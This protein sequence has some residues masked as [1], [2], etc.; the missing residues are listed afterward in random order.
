MSN[1]S[2]LA[3]T[4][5]AFSGPYLRWLEKDVLPIISGTL[6][7]CIFM[8]GVVLNGLTIHAVRKKRVTAL[9]THLFLQLVVLDFVA[10]VF[11]IF[12]AII[13]SF[14]KDWVLSEALCQISGAIGT[15]C[16][17]CLFIFLTFLCAE[18]M[19]KLNNPSVHD[20]FFGNKCICIIT[21]IVT[22]VVTFI[23]SILPVAGWGKLE[24][25]SSQ[26]RC[27][28]NHDKNKINMNLIFIFGMFLPAFM[29]FLFSIG[30][31]LQ[32]KELLTSLKSLTSYVNNVNVKVR[33]QTRAGGVTEKI[34]LGEI[35]GDQTQCLPEVENVNRVLTSTEIEVRNATSPVVPQTSRE[36]PTDNSLYPERPNSKNSIIVVNEETERP[37]SR[38][39]VSP[40]TEVSGSRTTRSE[41]EMK[42]KL[43]KDGVTGDETTFE[44][45]RVAV[46]VYK[47]SQEQVDF[48]LAATYMLIWVIV[49]MLWLPYVI[50]WYL[51]VYDVVS[52][53]GGVY[54]V[55]VIVC[56]VSY[57]IKPIVFM[58]HNHLFR[59]ATS[60]GV[61]ESLKTRVARAKRVLSKTARRVDGLIFLK[62]GDD[63]RT[64]IIQK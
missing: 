40:V 36:T 12:P 26:N 27:N 8:C 54:S 56:D 22:W 32:R 21:S 19:V 51:D 42:N 1:S 31:F 63:S 59:K 47:R 23:G 41:N 15:T 37:R 57:C 62:M 10:Y 46:T 24:Y 44:S 45:K 60:D 9:C 13:T 17:V 11:V 25:I 39:S 52:V 43:I 28:I 30:T 33:R 34:K 35:V 50:V 20:G 16:F 2:S 64:P 61:P 5:E 55:L 6:L 38:N 18:R 7:L 3:D 14:A 53:W 48:H 29:S 58:S 4:V 49:I